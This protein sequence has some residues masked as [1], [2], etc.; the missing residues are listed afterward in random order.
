M[1]ILVKYSAD[2]HPTPL[3]RAEHDYELTVSALAR[4]SDRHDREFEK[5]AW[6]GKI[7]AGGVAN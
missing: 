6:A 1:R 4:Q 3:H 5:N 2:T 7:V